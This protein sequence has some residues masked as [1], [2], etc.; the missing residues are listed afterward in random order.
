MMPIGNT[1]EQAYESGGYASAFGQKV[2]FGTVWP[3]FQRKIVSVA[4][5]G[6]GVRNP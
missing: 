3:D 2:L 4:D 5:N 6:N 1:A